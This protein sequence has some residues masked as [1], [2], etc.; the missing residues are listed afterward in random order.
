MSAT[1]VDIAT[2]C[3]SKRS[4]GNCDVSCLEGIG[5]GTAEAGA[6]ALIG[7]AAMKTALTGVIVESMMKETII[8]RVGAGGTEVQALTTGGVGVGV[9]VAGETEVQLGMAAKRGAQ[10]LSSGTGKKNR[11]NLITGLMQTVTTKMKAMRMDL[12]LTK[13]NI[14]INN[15]K[16]VH[17]DNE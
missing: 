15:D 4:A 16:K 12:L 1:A 9:P 14:I 5:Q 17:M 3:T 11:Q 6:E 2:L 7:I 10:E 8:M 13:I